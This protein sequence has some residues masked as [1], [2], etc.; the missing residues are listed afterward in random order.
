MFRVLLRNVMANWLGF[1]VNAAV[2]F[3][4]T[5]FVLRSLGDTRYG[6]WVLT[7]SI[8]GYYGLLDL[9]IRAGVTQYL[10]RY[11]ANNEFG[12]AN[13][14]VSS[15]FVLLASVGILISI[16][17][18]IIGLLAP[19]LFQIPAG[20]ESE[21]FWCVLVVG[22]AA[23]FQCAFF[24]VSA[25]F[26]ATQR[27]DLSNCIGVATRL[28]SAAAIWL[29]LK[30]GQGLL[31]LTLITLAS[32]VID[33]GIRCI[34]AFH[35][36]PQLRISPRLANWQDAREVFCF[37]L[38]NL[39]ISLNNVVILH[40]DAILIGI[41]L[42]LSAVTVY[43]LAAALAMQLGTNLLGGARQVFYP[44]AV[45]LYARRDN[46]GLQ[47]L[48]FR[49]SRLLLLVTIVS[50]TMVGVW[51]EDFYRLWVGS[52]EI[53]EPGLRTAAMLARVLLVAVVFEFAS[54]TAGQILL[55]S[56]RVKVLAIIALSQALL[57]LLVSVALIPFYGLLGAAIGT[58]VACL[59]HRTFIT[60]WLVSRQ[61]SL[62]LTSYVSQVLV[63]P[64]CVGLL[65]LPAAITLQGWY[66]PHTWSRLI[67]HVIAA[68]VVGVLLA[69]WIGVEPDERRDLIHRLRILVNR[70]RIQRP[71][72]TEQPC[73][74][75]TR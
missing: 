63:R 3:F 14:T 9:G 37:G 5:P 75:S 12:K 25:V 47:Q 43:A 32:V 52:D 65:F 31:G 11:L 39:F 17:S 19:R 66:P 73:D 21:T 62:P 59:V 56:G 51:A 8:I 16:V 15:A 40:T 6:I 7:T 35:L 53:G 61:L 20:M 54:G 10:T 4:L 67:A 69:A 57:N 24:P 26:V 42:P 38:W 30:M 49:G 50:A 2:I 45:D 72:A 18:L 46:H 36:V 58:L 34:V 71:S 44:A 60:V 28:G 23:A 70:N 41:F 13:S 48:L 74:A 33:Y 22:C 29:S 27:Y 55:G 64:I 1:A 68:A